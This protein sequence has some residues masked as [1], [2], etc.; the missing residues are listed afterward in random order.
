MKFGYTIL[1]VNNIE[2]T[3]LFYENA[4]GLERSFI[5]ESGYAELKS[6]S[7]K[8]AF[9]SIELAKS[10]GLNFEPSAISK[11]SFGFEIGLVTDDVSK[12]FEKAVNAGATPLTKPIQKPWGQTIAYVRDINGFILEICSPI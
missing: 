5:H 4:F 6:E 11:L 2:E 10:N 12:S 8:L 7:T 9:A 1:Y 3:I